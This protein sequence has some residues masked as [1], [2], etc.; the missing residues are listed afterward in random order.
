MLD[1][2]TA[3][4]CLRRLQ[5]GELSAVELAGE[6]LARIE[7]A[8][9]LN[10]VAAL[11]GEATLAAAAEADAARAAG[12]TAPL[13]GLPLTIKDTIAVAGMPF[14]SGSLAREHTIAQEDSTVVARLRRAGAVVAA[15]T[16]VPE[17][18]WSY[19]TESALQ[20][21]TLNAFDPARTSGGSSGG[22]G[23]LIGRGAS[24]AGLGT[25]GGGSIRVP[26]HYNGI[27]GLRPTAG[28]VPETG[29]WPTT[30]DTGMLDMVCIGP[31]ARSVDDIALLIRTIAGR[32]GYD[33]FVSVDGY[34]P[35]HRALDP[36]TLRVGFYAQDGVWPASVETEEAVRRAASALEDAGATVEETTPPAL[37][38]A[39]DIFFR[40]MAADGGARARADLAPA[41]GRHIEQ[42]LFVLELTKDFAVD[43]EGFFRLLGR[44]EAMRSRL[45]QFVARY[46]VVLSPVTPAPA[47]LHGC[48]PGDEPLDSYRPWVNVMSYSIAGTPV[49]VVPAGTERGMPIGV[50]LAA[51]PFADHVALAAAAVVEAA[52]GGY[53]AISAPLHLGAPS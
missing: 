34:T 14:R 10:A 52:L 1:E 43:A 44:W 2:L 51:N 19:E 22:E 24:I 8:S 23:T 36:S 9:D 13:L 7:A 42:M 11:D 17:Y 29:H 27:V 48:Q 39:E 35:D 21:R 6:T 49:A 45:R 32:D 50:H 33:P 3:A 26:S 15:K 25:D 47:P 20:G 31:M 18:A 46:D 5:A 30:R 12:S 53:A 41:N 16:A 4:E 38:E 40:M 28:L 37:D